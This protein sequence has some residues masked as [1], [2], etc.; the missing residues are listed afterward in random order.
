VR[1]LRRVILRGTSLSLALTAVG[2]V[3]LGAA[4][5][6][7]AGLTS[8]AKPKPAS[9]VI[10]HAA[11]SRSAGKSTKK[12]GKKTGKKAS[13]RVTAKATQ[14]G[15]TD[16][17]LSGGA[18]NL[19]SF[20]L[21]SASGS[22][23]IEDLVVQATITCVNQPEPAPPVDTEIIGGKLAVAKNGSFSTG[24]IKN[25]NGTTVSGTV[26]AGSVTVHYHHQSTLANQ[27]EGGNYVCDTGNLT[28]DG[29]PGTRLAITNGIWNGETARN[30][31][32]VLNVADGGRVLAPVVKP[33][34]AVPVSYPAKNS[35]SGLWG[36]IAFGAFTLGAG[37][38]GAQPGSNDNCAY[39]EP[40]A[41]FI[42][43]N[44]TFGDAQ[45]YDGDTTASEGDGDNPYFDG[46]F[47][48]TNRVSGT[49]SNAA[50]ACNQY[51]WSA[52]P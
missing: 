4:I 3:V 50:E 43:S 10:A 22:S 5:A 24:R 14:A 26:S 9:A 11:R 1:N 18:N 33:T 37:T 31:P 47:T 7:A 42:A 34:V 25:G 51:D 44:G 13:P 46:H 12:T 49:V 21:V 48:A 40:A 16:Y 15:G 35:E 41:Q 19:A 29:K 17:E 38:G 28:L 20:D 2:I 52:R 23:K 45:W 6:V 27:Y 32:V 36:S 30:E 39:N 8:K